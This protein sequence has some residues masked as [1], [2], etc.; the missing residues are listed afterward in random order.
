[1]YPDEAGIFF[2]QIIV[3]SGG[4]FVYSSTPPAF[5]TLVQS[6]AATG[7]TDPYG[8]VYLAG[9]VSY[10]PVAGMFDAAANFGGAV[11]LYTAA[12][13]AGPW[14]QL[15]VLQI[16]HGTNETIKLATTPGTALQL[17]NNI[18][19]IE[20]TGTAA[21]DT[22]LL[23]GILGIANQVPHLRPGTYQIN[24]GD[25]VLTALG[26]AQYI[27]CE[28]GVT[29]SAFGSGDLL[30][31]S[32]AGTY[33]GSTT[34]RGG[35]LGHPIIDGA[36]T[37]GS[38]TA[39][40]AGDIADL[41]FEAI[42]RNWRSG[43]VSWG[44]LLDNQNHFTEH[45]RLD[46][47]IINC[48]VSPSNGGGLGFTVTSPG[49]ALTSTESFARLYG[50][51]NIAPGTNQ[52]DGLVLANGARIYDSPFFALGGDFTSSGAATTAAIV[53][54]TGQV[55][56]GHPGAGN[57]SKIDHSAIYF[58][59]ET[60]NAGANPPQSI[61]FGSFGNNVITGTGLIDFGSGSGSPAT[62]GPGNVGDS[63]NFNGPVMGGDLDLFANHDMGRVPV[64]MGDPANGTILGEGYAGLIRCAPTAARTGL[65]L[66]TGNVTGSPFL[67]G[68]RVTVV[69]VAAYASGFDL[70]FDVVATSH[71]SGGAATVIKAGQAKSFQWSADDGLWYP[72][73]LS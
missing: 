29:I 13:E 12:T 44:M 36:N 15:G 45:T 61:A 35:I 4:V 64:Q 54:I 11:T 19:I 50:R 68:R 62:A 26:V 49:G 17:Q 21:G 27:V 18:L 63:F 60:D 39:I 20:P 23:S 38:A 67:S 28:P 31:W 72:I 25:P 46:L 30:A 47:D 10:R 58:T 1:M 6:I 32:F 69:N 73:G 55:P 48:G 53:R 9:D 66:A 7:G 8:N 40:H 41:E 70:T 34:L 5:G 42:I 59:P 71:V 43:T 56:A 51:V 3:G 37:T 33:N 24:C 52:R 22:S 16:F 65:I 2:Q 14:T 57:Y